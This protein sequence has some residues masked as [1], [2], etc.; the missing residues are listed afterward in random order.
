MLIAIIYYPE[1]PVGMENRKMKP[2]SPRIRK[3]NESWHIDILINC[4]SIKIVIFKRQYNDTEQLINFK[5]TKQEFEW[6]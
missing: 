4:V 5:L 2:K 1:E 3:I 6:I